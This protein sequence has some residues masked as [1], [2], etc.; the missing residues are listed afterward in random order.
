MG[1]AVSQDSWC[2]LLDALEWTGQLSNRV[3]NLVQVEGRSL[4]DVAA[5]WQ[6]QLKAM[7]A[8]W[9]RRDLVLLIRILECDI[10]AVLEEVQSR[11]EFYILRKESH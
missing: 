2:W 10:V 3:K 8:A 6:E 9:E 4:D 1:E 7:L 11:F 5:R